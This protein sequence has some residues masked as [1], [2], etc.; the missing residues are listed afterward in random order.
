MYKKCTRNVRLAFYSY[1][2]AYQKSENIWES[3]TPSSIAPTNLAG[4]NREATLTEAETAELDVYEQL[5]HLFAITNYK[6]C[7]G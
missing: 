1:L 4:K 3:L 2:T 5:E 6:S 7:L